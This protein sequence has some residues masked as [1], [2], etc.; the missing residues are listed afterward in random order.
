MTS[1]IEL[2]SAVE[3]S[4]ADR[5]GD[6]GEL[7]PEDR[8]GDLAASDPPR[9][10]NRFSAQFNRF[11]R[12]DIFGVNAA[13]LLFVLAPL[14]FGYYARLHWSAYSF[15][16][17]SRYYVVMALRD[18]GWGD[19][20]A[21]T[22]QFANSGVVAEPWYFAHSDPAWL[23]VQSRMLYPFFAAPFVAVFGVSAG[24][25][26][27][28]MAAF[29]TMLWAVTRLVQRLYG[30]T[31]ALAAGGVLGACGFLMTLAEAVTDSVAIAVLALILLNL[32]LGRR[33]RANNLIALALLS[34]LLELSRQV[35]PTA[36]VMAFFA[37]VWATL[38]P[39]RGRPRRWRNDWLW[40]SLIVGG[41]T[42]FVHLLEAKLSGRGA[43]SQVSQVTANPFRVAWTITDYD[44]LSTLQGDKALSMLLAGALLFVVVRFTDIVAG[45]LLGAL[46]G[47]YVIMVAGVD[48]SHMRYESIMFPVAGLA[49]GALFHHLAPP[50]LRGGVVGEGTL[51][52]DRLPPV[53]TWW[54]RGPRRIQALGACSVVGLA[55]LVGW[56]GTHGSKSMAGTIPTAPS[57]AAAMAGN[58]H[59]VIPARVVP[60]E[61]TLSE[62]FT[63]A[64]NML[65]S[66]TS[67]FLIYADWRHPMHFR[68]LAANEPGWNHRGADGT[69]VIYPGDLASSDW[70]GL[71]KAFT[72]NGTLDPGTV[73]V[74][75][76]T[77]SPYGED[78]TFTV[79]AN[80]TVHRG[81]A[82][83]LYPVRAALPGFVPEMVFDS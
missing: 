12:R 19:A 33:A 47:T 59:A 72:Y 35:M 29:A 46:A 4:V 79:V 57:A 15:P 63:Q 80:K 43:G 26:L 75:S 22:K 16:P 6:A 7:E 24:M 21:L 9:P 41:T 83:V 53:D 40:P 44:V 69:V 17:D 70:T 20:H 8:N 65:Q 82:T 42:V 34:V 48:P 38:F 28:A 39:G 50:S 14:A 1:E 11:V 66:K 52:S 32:P 81:H 77:T 56:S 3:P 13:V 62:E 67:V 10:G 30:P 51:R 61:E 27:A 60:A 31:A 49:I 45:L 2:T 55:F 73:K 71:A 5:D 64:E 76:R 23:M 54:Q 36:A 18:L 37:Y 78:V 58:S 74:T 25:P 68:P